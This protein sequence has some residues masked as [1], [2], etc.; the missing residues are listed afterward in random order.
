[1]AKE[2]P[3][4]VLRG[5]P[6]NIDAEA[7]LL[8]AILID[9]N[10]ADALIPTLKPEDFYLSKNRIIFEAMRSL[11]ETSKPVDTVSVADAL[12]LS[13]QLDEIGSIMYLSE[14]AESVPSAA[15]SDYYARI[16]KRDAL[17]RRVIEAG[18][19]ITQY[20]YEASEGGDALM[21]AE[22]VIFKISEE[23]SDKHLLKA[24][25]ALAEAMK[26]IQDMQTGNIPK[27]VVFTDFP[28]LDRKTKGL[29]PGEMVLVA[30]RP[31]VGKTAL[32]LNIA[33]N[34]CLNHGKT[35]A[36]FSLE[37]P[38]HLLVK[39]MLAYVSKVSLTKMDLQGGL[40]V[41]ENAKL[42]QAYNSLLTTGLYIDDYSMNTPTDVLSKCRRLKREKGL[43]LII[44]DYMQLMTVKSER[45]REPESRQL[46]V[47]TIS[48]N[49]KLYAK[50]LNVPILLLSQ[51][52]RGVEQR[53]D[54]SPQLSDL[55]ESGSIEQDADIVM[56]LNRES[57]FN[58]AIPENQIKLDVKKNRNGP[59]GEITLEW[60]GDTTSFKECVAAAEQAPDARVGQEQNRIAQKA[61]EETAPVEVETDELP[62]DTQ[63]AEGRKDAGRNSGGNDGLRHVDENDLNL[64]SEN[65]GSE[66]ATAG[67]AEQSAAEKVY[68]GNAAAENVTENKTSADAGL[69]EDV[70]SPTDDDAPNGVEHDEAE[71]DGEIED[72]CGED[73]EEYDD[74]GDDL[75]L[76]DV[77][78]DDLPF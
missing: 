73:E 49:M 21:N 69:Y 14:L 64:A 59:I 31:S 36:I 8:G 62:W 47:S 20:A 72:S 66:S 35:V 42:F 6:N 24:D 67:S 13:G 44:I 18:N 12:E 37:M 25:D 65:G 76:R 48:R 38:A 52:S 9:N 27:N 46:E 56:F 2:K 41:R 45:G 51:M 60:D 75:A 70:P 33:A 78:S 11:Q 55:R 34:A 61:P 68:A 5:M 7:S 15:N 57:Q 43:D 53:K 16:I 10:A 54:H 4:K 19:E 74:G 23:K 3:K 26:G 30:A 40:S 29:K 39:R 63:S 71:N 77:D 1:M 58:S 17:T 22:R 32:A 28:S 50:E